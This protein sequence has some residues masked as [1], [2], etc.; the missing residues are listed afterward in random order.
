MSSSGVL[1]LP[2]NDRPLES[3]VE[4]SDDVLEKLIMEYGGEDPAEEDGGEG[5]S[6]RSWCS[7][8]CRYDDCLGLDE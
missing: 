4:L 3:G 7:A 1:R 5:E 6:I 8:G 2:R